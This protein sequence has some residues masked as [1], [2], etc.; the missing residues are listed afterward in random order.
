A[1][2]HLADPSPGSAWLCPRLDRGPVGAGGSRRYCAVSADGLAAGALFPEAGAGGQ[3]CPGG[4][5]LAAARLVGD[6]SATAAVCPT[7]ARCYFR[8]LPCHCSAPGAAQL[9]Q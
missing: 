2:P 3:L 5:A 6:G 9:R 8:L 4:A 7:V 1:L